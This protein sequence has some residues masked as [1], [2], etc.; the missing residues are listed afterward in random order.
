MLKI[1][2]SLFGKVYDL[3]EDLSSENP[4]IK[5]GDK[6]YEIS[7]GFK[8]VMELD[9]LFKEN[10]SDTE[11][12]EKFLKV[13]LGAKASKELLDLNKTLPFYKK[14]ITIIGDEIKGSDDEEESG[15]T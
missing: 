13:A 2:L 8:T 7:T 5:V 9:K 4:V 3:T 15:N 6:E 11:F 12:V 1:N 14:I 10:H